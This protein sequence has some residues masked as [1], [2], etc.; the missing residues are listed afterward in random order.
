M[1]LEN[2]VFDAKDKTQRTIILLHGLGA[3]GND[4]APLIPMLDLSPTTKVILPHAPIIP[5]TVNGGFEMRAWYDISDVELRNKDK[6]GIESSAS[7]IEKIID[8]EIEQGIE[9]ANILLAG[10]SQGGAMCLYFATNYKQKLAGVL[11]MSG[12]LL[13]DE[14]S[15]AGDKSQMPIFLMHGKLDLVVSNKLGK[16][17]H[18]KLLAKNYKADWKEYYMQHEVCPEQIEDIKNWL[19]ALNF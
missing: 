8:A 4:F 9:P 5:V 2:I 17:A 12:Y 16:A 15:N 14:P 19:K 3:D 6:Q 7:I 13:E 10:F 11:C 1:S 18:T